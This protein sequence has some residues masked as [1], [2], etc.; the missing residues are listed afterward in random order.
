M[1]DLHYTL[2]GSNKILVFSNKIEHRTIIFDD[3]LDFVYEYTEGFFKFSKEGNWLEI[4]T[5]PNVSME[6]RSVDIRIEKKDDSSRFLYLSII[7]QGNSYDLSLNPTV[8]KEMSPNID[9]QI[10]YT[11]DIRVKGGSE[12]CYVKDIKRFVKISS[13]SDDFIVRDDYDNA[14]V[15]NINF[16]GQNGEGIMEITNMGRLSDDT[17]YY[18]II[19]A[20]SEMPSVTKTI[21]LSYKDDKNDFSVETKKLSFNSYGYSVNDDGIIY[22]KNNVGGKIEPID[23]DEEWLYLEYGYNSIKVFTDI[24]DSLSERKTELSIGGK[25]VEI[26]QNGM[27]QPVKEE[28]NEIP[29]PTIIEHPSI[30]PIEINGDTIKVVTWIYEGG[31]WLNNSRINIFSTTPW[32]SYRINEIVD[33]NGKIY[34][35]AK[36]KLEPNM[37]SLKRMCEITITNAE[38][39]DKEL[40]YTIIQDGYPNDTMQITMG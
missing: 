6:E 17:Q 35:L 40:S 26:V 2:D 14:L 4:I 31:K 19:V 38:K 24:N 3:C 15:V 1:E 30:E 10:K 21:R 39:S 34:H 27:P 5:T 32:L 20:H 18:D 12:R 16:N 37:F 33:N 36:I 25:T 22:L 28:I 7:Q 8:I 23:T 11:I 29:E 13:I 9:N